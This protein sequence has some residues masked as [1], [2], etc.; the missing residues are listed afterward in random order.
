MSVNDLEYHKMLL[1]IRELRRVVEELGSLTKPEIYAGI[2]AELQRKK[3]FELPHGQR[4]LVDE[5]VLILDRP[6][7]SPEQ[8]RRLARAFHT[9]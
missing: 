7:L 4:E 2:E 3:G 6:G 1:R 8:A 9:F 5:I